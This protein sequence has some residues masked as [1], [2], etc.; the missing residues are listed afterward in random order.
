MAAIQFNYSKTVQQATRLEEI[1]G[2]LLNISNK[3]IQT[4]VDQ[5]S[6]A[7]SGEAAQIF[8]QYSNGISDDLRNKANYLSTLAKT[9][10]EVAKTIK[11]AEDQAKLLT[12]A[13]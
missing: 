8:I 2:D 5:V 3:R 7:W 1:S 13:K 10:R 11:A 12:S 4:V 6:G 9:L